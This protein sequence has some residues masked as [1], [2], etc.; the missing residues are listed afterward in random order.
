MGVHRFSAVNVVVRLFPTAFRPN[1]P[2]KN[3][4]RHLLALEPLFGLD[5]EVPLLKSTSVTNYTR[6]RL[7]PSCSSAKKAAPMTLSTESPSSKGL[8]RTREGPTTAQ[9]PPQQIPASS[10]TTSDEKTVASTL[11][12]GLNAVPQR[13][14][15]LTLQEYP[16]AASSRP[17]LSRHLQF[18][19]SGAVP[20]VTSTSSSGTTTPAR[21]LT[22]SFTK[23]TP[24]SR[25]AS[26]ASG[27]QHDLHTAADLLR[28]AMMQR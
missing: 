4:S 9:A 26:M 12:D 21:R 5:L 10:N 23:S 17:P 15:R 18:K 16:L 25:R 8:P 1:Q 27:A 20:T 7:R 14:R 2:D 11:K 6:A 22:V 13:T 28:Q 24:S 3:T 19:S